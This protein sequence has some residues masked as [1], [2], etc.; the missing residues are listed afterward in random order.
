LNLE[1]TPIGPV[2]TGG[3]HLN[4]TAA[5]VG[6]LRVGAIEMRDVDVVVGDFLDLLSQVAGA[7]LD[8]IV[9]YNFSAK[10]TKS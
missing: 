4:L 6:S 7:K 1:T 10:T 3:A 2:T 5:R 9:G 8:G